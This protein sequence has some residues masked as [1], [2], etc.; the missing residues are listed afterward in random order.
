M[1]F[2]DD[3]VMRTISDLVKAIARLFLGKD[4]VDYDLPTNEADDTEMDNRFRRLT[5]LA[6]EGNINEAE[7]LLFE[8]VDPAD[9]K[10][11]EMALAFYMYLNE[12]DDDFLYT[13][14]YS[15]EE[16]V[17]GI[18]AISAEF[19]ITGFEHF[20]DT[21]MVLRVW[22]REISRK[23]TQTAPLIWANTTGSCFSAT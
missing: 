20:V 1:G 6:E 7:N 21:T 11:L 10:Y 5:A 3:Y 19:G 4:N 9:K 16:I 14:N 18:N 12:F 8:E 23:R 2:Q 17:D 13:N 22:M 15:R